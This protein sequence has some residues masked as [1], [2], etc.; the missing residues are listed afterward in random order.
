[1]RWRQ[2]ERFGD[3]VEAAAC[4]LP[5]WQRGRDGT[6]ARAGGVRRPSPPR[7]PPTSSEGARCQGA[8]RP[9][10]LQARGAAPRRLPL[11][12]AAPDAAPHRAPAAA[13]RAMDLPR[14]LLV[15][16]TLSLW[17][18]TCPSCFPL[19]LGAPASPPWP[20]GASDPAARRGT[21][22][23]AQ[24]RTLAAL[25]DVGSRELA[26]VQR[27]RQVQEKRETRGGALELGLRC[28]WEK[29]KRFELKSA[30]GGWPHWTAWPPPRATPGLPHRRDGER[31]AEPA[32]LG[33]PPAW[34]GE[35]ILKRGEPGAAALEGWGRPRSR[36][37]PGVPPAGDRGNPQG[38]RLLGGGEQ[39]P[40]R[41]KAAGCSS[42]AQGPRKRYL[43]LGVGTGH[44]PPARA[45]LCN[46]SVIR[47]KPLS[48]RRARRRLM[49]SRCRG[50]AG[51]SGWPGTRPGMR[52]QPWTLRTG[53]PG[54][55]FPTPGAP[56]RPST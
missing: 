11:W 51:T 5:R 48:P 27:L 31:R 3:G 13:P 28:V 35:S 7:G 18:G 1:M 4:R 42:A 16:W 34:R 44:R 39:S 26:A 56:A 17:P 40:D 37:P 29:L 21:R 22:C 19:P 20:A 52:G 49:H 9:R 10:A 45:Q 33:C 24:S 30:E 43:T 38:S 8:G 6:G 50:A 12:L 14:G 46:D 32:P 47:G 36:K 2:K 25:G 41:P 55:G 53:A 15:A 23:A 54:P